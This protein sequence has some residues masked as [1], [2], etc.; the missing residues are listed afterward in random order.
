MS[1]TEL[2]RR[3]RLAPALLGLLAACSDGGTEPPVG[4]IVAGVDLD[5]LFADPEPWEIQ[6]IEAEWAG[7][8]PGAADA[9]IERDTVVA[10]GDSIRVR[11][12]SHDVEGVRHYGGI[13]TAKAPVGPAPVVVYAHGGDAGVSLNDVLLL[14]AFLGDLGG[15]FVWV[16]PSFRAE[17]LRLFTEV[18]TS[19]GPASPWD[20]DVDDALSLLDVVL[21]L[22]P[23]AD[24]GRIGAFGL[25]RGGGVAMLMGIRD[26]RIDRVVEFFGPT[27]FFEAYV[28]EVTAEALRGSPR[29]LPGLAFLD[30]TFIQPLRRG[31]L[32]VAE[33]R[34]ELIRRSAVL[35]AERLPALQVHHGDA[36]DV[37]DVG[38]AESLIATMAALGRGAPEFES[39]IYQGGGHSLLTLPG[40]VPRAVDFFSEL[41][42]APATP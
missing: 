4:R 36:D 19:E 18:F 29:D 37:V 42:S 11:V 26:P 27:D 32:T 24:P 14:L 10:V 40:S 25:S 16:V 28:Q 21:Q 1:L 30:E 9:T 23:A 6:A 31:E 15:E 33:V 20:R 8:S 39:Y 17:S 13:I 22:E 2:L 38:Q 7:R 5:V 35:F 41:L 12:V 34:P 3:A